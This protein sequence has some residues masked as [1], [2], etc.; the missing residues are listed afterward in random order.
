MWASV[1]DQ[2]A[3]PHDWGT[4]VCL[5]SLRDP[6]SRYRRWSTRTLRSA[7]KEHHGGCWKRPGQDRW[8]GDIVKHMPACRFG[9]PLRN[10]PGLQCF[11]ATWPGWGASGSA[12]LKALA[13]PDRPGSPNPGRDNWVGLQPEMTQ[14][15]AFPVDR[16]AWHQRNRGQGVRSVV[17]RLEEQTHPAL[18]GEL[19]QVDP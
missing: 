7:G 5:G 6:D 18:G 8:V 15:D 14:V 10:R 1:V 11:D 17:N 16:L 4:G 19:K 3:V 12:P 13:R 2:R 9:A